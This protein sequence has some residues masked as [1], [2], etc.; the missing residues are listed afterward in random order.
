VLFRL[1]DALFTDAAATPPTG[2]TA[3]KPQ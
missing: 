3:R 2:D 1:K